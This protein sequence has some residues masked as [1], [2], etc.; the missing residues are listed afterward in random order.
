[1]TIPR[2]V[3][4]R[5]VG[6]GGRSVR[7]V[8]RITGAMIKLSADVRRLESGS[9]SGMQAYSQEQQDLILQ[10]QAKHHKGHWSTD[11]LVLVEIY[12]T[13]IATQVT[14]S[15]SS[16][17]LLLLPSAAAFICCLPLL[18]SAAAFCCCFLLLPSAAFCCCLYLLPSA[19]AFCC[20]FLLL[21]SAAAFCCCFLLLP[22]AAAFCYCLLLLPF[23][24]FN[25]R[26]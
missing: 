13:F 15:N 8:Q 26:C 16:S 4:G 20:C 6:R 25:S 11:Q 23:A 9:W 10:Q 18:P 12:G 3:A 19:A 2:S 17:S 1:M 14:S 24:A 21:L 5:V 7:E 22:S